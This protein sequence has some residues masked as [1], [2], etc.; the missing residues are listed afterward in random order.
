MAIERPLPPAVRQN[1]CDHRDDLDQHLE[2][3]EIAGLNRESFR[4]SYGTQAT[5]Q[6]LAPNNDHGHPCRYQS[7]I[8]LHQG[9]ERRG[10]EQLIG[11][12][13]QQNSNRRDLPSLARQVS[14]NSIGDGRQDEQRRGQYLS[15]TMLA[16]ESAAGKNPDQQGDA[17][18]AAERNVVWQI[19]LRLNSPPG[20]R[21]TFKLSSTG[22]SESNEK[23]AA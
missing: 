17:E 5:H 6:E 22:Y 18:N 2:F 9:H 19:H 4:S 21:A 8:E 16:A 23:P 13:I 20:R 7:G 15:L 1:H 11:Q 14:V 3:S 12:G 10:D